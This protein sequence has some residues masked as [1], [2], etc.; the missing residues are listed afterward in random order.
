MKL[1]LQKYSN[2]I[3]DLCKIPDYSKDLDEFHSKILKK[4][5]IFLIKRK[6]IPEIWIKTQLKKLKKKPTRYLN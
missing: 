2:N 1:K 5:F 6:R 4:I 3:W